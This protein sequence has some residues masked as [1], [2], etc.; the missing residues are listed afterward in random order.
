MKK[1]PMVLFALSFFFG[2]LYGVDH[3][4]IF[5]VPEIGGLILLFLEGRYEKRV[6]KA[7]PL[8][9]DTDGKRSNRIARMDR[10]LGFIGIVSV[11]CFL[12]G[13]MRMSD[14]IA[15]WQN[16]DKEK[17]RLSDSVT[18]QGTI[19][20]KEEKYHQQVYK[21]DRC[22]LNTSNGAVPC[23]G[24]LLYL[25]E[26]EPQYP[27][28]K[29]L[30]MQGTIEEFEEARNE[31]NFDSKVYY[32][33][34]GIKWKAKNPA[35]LSAKGKEKMV[36][37]CMYE[38]R[39]Q[40]AK[41]YVQYLKPEAASILKTM[42]LGD[43]SSMEEDV[44][45]MYQT[46]GVSHLLSIS[47]LHMML[48][49]GGSYGFLRKRG[50]PIGLSSIC[51]MTGAW[52]Y[53][54]F[55][56]NGVSLQRALGMLMLWF[57]AHI[58]GR[59]TDSLTSLFVI[60]LLLL[61]DNP[62]LLGSNS[63]QFSFLA[64]LGVQISGKIVAE[65]TYS[66]KIGMNL[67]IQAATL[68][69]VATC[70]GEIPWYVML[71]NLLLVPL[72]G[73]LLGC[74]LLGGFLLLRLPGLGKVVLIPCRG[75]L[76]LYHQ[77]GRL[78]QVLPGNL[79]ITGEPKAGR[80]VIYFLVLVGGLFFF[81]GIL[82]CRNKEGRREKKKEKAKT[83]RNTMVIAGSW[84]LLLTFIV[85]Y[86]QPKSNSITFLDVGQ[87]E[88]IC[89]QEGHK[90]IFI[91]G[92][93]SDVRE[94]GK[95][96]I[97]PYLKHKGIREIDYW[98]VSHGDMDHVSGLKEIL[99]CGYKVKNLVVSDGFDEIESN[100][101]L[102]LL[103]RECGVTIHKFQQGDQL[104]M[105]KAKLICISPTMGSFRKN[106]GGEER[107]ETEESNDAS[108][109]LLYQREDFKCVMT[110][111]LSVEG[112]KAILK[113]GLLEKYGIKNIQVLK[114]G[115]HGSKTASSKEWIEALSP[116]TCVI[117]C[118]QENMYG[119]PHGQVLELLDQAEC[120]VLRTDQVG[121]IRIGC[122]TKAIITQQE[123]R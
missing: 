31:G 44:K 19:I 85:I 111:D 82:T 116:E 10:V 103:A 110:G 72:A 105:G 30:V 55:A 18:F 66:D 121:Q 42:V 71:C 32:G 8:E 15:L 122:D 37:E 54:Q 61:W 70:Y 97:L 119:H 38:L 113:S 53:S 112:E 107:T 78:I 62:F 99:E 5:V 39:S 22:Y 63:F 100:E 57:V 17:L 29:T 76:F 79:I 16:A 84:L 86:P 49:F 90:A 94:V 123:G 56:G 87:G 88:G 2:L 9:S 91:D 64:V 81:T 27:I 48:L 93:S 20:S 50:V 28:G 80:L 45:R 46:M 114:A 3:N 89:I 13:N 118:G 12:L 102:L 41:A 68:W 14:S 73:I 65:Y 21:L 40:M 83:M 108:L 1:R 4:A 11:A 75:I 95:Y 96:R 26:K 60:S 36:W 33:C 43:R 34:L 92:G 51:G 23:N 77:L 109:C 104:T 35:I 59:T 69:M 58:I 98:F 7:D 115:H 25:G 67:G 52:I 106:N 47:G 6:A 24:I 120:E 117:S 101:E 74:G